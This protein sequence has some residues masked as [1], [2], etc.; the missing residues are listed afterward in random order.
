M[1][2][3]RYFV[4]GAGR[5]GQAVIYD[6]VRHCSACIVNVF[7]PNLTTQS[8]AEKRLKKLLGKQINVVKFVS[9]SQVHKYVNQVA[10]DVIISC[11]P[12]TANEEITKTAI[13]AK[14]PMVDLGGNPAMVAKQEELAKGQNTLIVPECGISPGISNIFA[15][16][17][18][19]QGMSD[20]KVRC[21]GVPLPK[22]DNGF[23]HKSVFSIA[24]LLSEYS[25]DV[26]F[27]R[28]GELAYTKAL[29]SIEVDV[30]SDIWEWEASPTSNNSPQVVRNLLKMGARNYNYMTLRHPGHWGQ[31]LTLREEGVL[32]AEYLDSCTDLLYDHETDRDILIL[33]VSGSNPYCKMLT[34]NHTYNLRIEA[35]PVTKFSAM[36]LTTA[37]GATIVAWD[38]CISRMARLLPKGF[39]TPEEFLELDTLLIA[40]QRRIVRLQEG[41]Y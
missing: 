10:C 39:K 16:G 8:S 34:E 21:G 20:I 18:I 31:V 9:P 41:T 36:E 38:V 4:F 14:V 12:Y 27:I 17:L 28:D 13:S 3:Y 33:R 25:G 6:L 29:S 32:T 1:S 19:K 7:E 40:L 30:E 5:V 15:A 24:G 22:P 11:A 35:D 26:P 2:R 37:W 23:F